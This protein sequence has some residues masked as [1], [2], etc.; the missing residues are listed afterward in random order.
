M[1]AAAMVY[2]VF[3]FYLFKPYLTAF[4]RWDYLLAISPVAGALGCYILSRRW[5]I[6]LAGSFFAGALYG[7]GPFLLGMMR[8]HPTAGLLAGA[9]P[10]CFFPA[11]RYTRNKRSPLGAVLALGPVVVVF[12][13]FQLGARWKF[14]PMPIQPVIEPRDL[15]SL[16]APLVMVKL[17]TSA[18]VGFYHVAAAA[19]V[20]GAVMVLKA[21]RYAIMAVFAGGVVLFLVR[22]VWAVSPVIWL[23]FPM[24]CCAVVAGEGIQGVLVAGHGDR[25]WILLGMIVEGVLAI[26]SL[27]LATKYFQ[28]VLSLA[29]GY[30][31]LFVGTAKMYLV[32]AVA[33]GLIFLIVRSN[34]R[35]RWLRVALLCLALAADIFLGARFVVDTIL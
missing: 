30:A 14:F 2:A 33:M 28:F 1:S 7:F 35:M 32:G 10:W 8:F 16:I 13:F 24:L 34:F 31:M 6:S 29:D 26:I 3:S 27:L 17:R 21:R 15:A 11:V 22:P 20:I 23:A 12:A 4:E 9:I 5:L 19:L 18:L 25:R